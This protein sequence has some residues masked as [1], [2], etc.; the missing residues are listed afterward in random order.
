MAN[1]KLEHFSRSICNAL[2]GNRFLERL[3]KLMENEENF[4]KDFGN[5]KTK[6]EWRMKEAWKN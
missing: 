5:I 3:E 6:I 2:K 4:E 1:L